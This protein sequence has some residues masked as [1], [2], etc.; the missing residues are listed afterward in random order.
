MAEKVK[1]HRCKVS[2]FKTEG[3]GCW[4]VEKALQDM[5]IEHEVVGES[6]LK[7]RRADVIRMT[8]QRYVPVIEFADGTAYREESKEMAARIRAGKLFEGHGPAGVESAPPAAS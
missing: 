2:W 5:G 7:G 6:Y 3:H 1:L 4:R 8:G